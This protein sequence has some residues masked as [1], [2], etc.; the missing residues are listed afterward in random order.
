MD[1]TSEFQERQGRLWTD[2][3]GGFGWKRPMRTRKLTLWGH[4]D[5]TAFQ[6]GPSDVSHCKRGTWGVLLCSPPTPA[7]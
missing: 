3:S 4:S 7:Q 6:G 1:P 2:C 5:Q